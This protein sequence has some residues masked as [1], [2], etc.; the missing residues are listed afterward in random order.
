M[1]TIRAEIA[2]GEF[3][4][5][6]ALEDVHLAIEKRLTALV[7]DA[8][9]RLHTGRSRNDQVATD[10]RLWLRGA[11]DAL[12]DSC[13][14]AA[15]AARRSPNA[16]PTSI[17]PGYTHLQV[18]QPVTFG[19]HLLA[20][21]AM[22]ARDAERFADC[23]RR[24]N[25]LPLGAAALAGT[26]FPIDREQVARELGF[27]GPLRQFARRRLRSRLRD[28]IRSA[29]TLV[30]VHLS[31]FA[32]EIVLWSTQR[33]ASSARRPLLHRQLDHAAEEKSRCGRTRPAARP[34]ASS[35]H[36]TALADADE[37]PAAGV[38]QGQPGRQGTVV[39]H[40]GHRHR[41]PRDHD[42]PRRHGIAT[43]GRACVPPR[44]KA[45]RRR[46]TLPIT[47]CAK[48]CRSATRTKPL[49]A[50]SAMP[51][52]SS[53]DLA[54]LPSP[55][56]RHSRRDRRRRL[57]PAHA[58]RI[59]CFA[60]PPRRH[61]TGTGACGDRRCTRC[62]RATRAAACVSDAARQPSFGTPIGSR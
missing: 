59:G 8:G 3:P 14:A 49:R 22:F 36:L 41:L 56:C 48:A 24:V 60:Q 55:S 30:M 23:R 20:Y 15:R 31:R 54:R 19:H 57:R 35:G 52:R 7:G 37:G 10:T 46:P 12:R 26:S 44:A 29:A 47:C 21:D 58:R 16:T 6:I 25:R 18:A 33:F 4:W 43:D 13:G 39:R 50:P 51:S 11:I 1:A 53:C 42:G 5:D 62:T 34:A 32:E 2:G 45:T 28:R 38:Q 40:R 61:G 9:K 17:M 27:D